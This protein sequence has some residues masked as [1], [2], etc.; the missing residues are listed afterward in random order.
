MTQQQRLMGVKEI[1]QR[2]GLSRQRVQQLAGRSD[3]PVPYDEL[4]MGRIWLV[5]DVEAWIRVYRPDR[6]DIAEH[7]R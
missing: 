2:L 5:R 6:A 4:A 7:E 3:F 1:Q